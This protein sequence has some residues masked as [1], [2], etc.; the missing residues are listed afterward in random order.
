M[1]AAPAKLRD[2]A[3]QWREAQTDAERKL[4]MRLRS[5]QLGGAKFRR[6]QPIGPFIADLCS[7]EHGLVIELD[8]GQHAA[9]AEADGRRTAFLER[10]G[11]RVLR[12]WDHEVLQGIEAVLERIHEA[13]RASSRRS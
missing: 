4:W 7:F 5:R 1:K 3:R 9:Q 8:G 6:Q 10:E 13:L 2:R 12:F 11:Y